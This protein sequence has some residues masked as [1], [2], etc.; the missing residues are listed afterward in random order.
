MG[1]DT[2]AG[3][4]MLRWTAIRSGFRE[5][6]IPGHHFRRMVGTT[7]TSCRRTFTRIRDATD[8]SGSRSLFAGV[9]ACAV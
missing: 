4:F 3:Y 8:H 2:K 9:R 6:E 1:G 7:P 5:V